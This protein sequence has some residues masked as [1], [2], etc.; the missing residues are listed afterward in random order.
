[1]SASAP[2][3][4]DGINDPVLIGLFLRAPPVLLPE[5]VT[6]NQSDRG[7]GRPRI[8]D[9][10][11]A[12]RPRSW[13]RQRP[14]LASPDLT[15]LFVPLL[16]RAHHVSVCGQYD[17]DAHEGQTVIFT[18][19][20][21]ATSVL[22]MT[23]SGGL[24]LTPRCPLERNRLGRS[25]REIVP[26]LD[27]DATQLR[28]A[29]SIIAFVLAARRKFRCI[30]GSFALVAAITPVDGI[31][32]TPASAPFVPVHLY[33]VSPTGDDHN[34]GT[35]P[36]TAWAT[37]R[38]PVQ[39]G[40]VIIA[41]AGR[42][43]QHVFGTNSWGDVANCPSTRDGV[44]GGG[45]VYFATLLCAGP[46]ITS[47]S[48]DG[49]AYEAF[50]VDASNWAVEGFTATQNSTGNSACFSAT[51]ETDTTLHHI[52]F[53]NDIAINC[54]YSGF[55][56]YSWTSPGG[57]DQT[58]V[59]GVIAYNA[60]S[61]FGGGI[62]SSGVSIVP[63]DGPDAELGTHVFVAGYFGYEN[64][65]AQSGAGCN[66]DGEELIFELLGMHKVHPPGC[67]RTECLVAKREL[68]V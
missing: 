5:L 35:S 45:G 38:H 68:R 42:Y 9:A 66:T 63:V 56:S 44:D 57:V 12:Q 16:P 33:Y 39:C 61:S 3:A 28:P 2:T 7:E 34:S 62:C 19:L 32:K 59:V 43:R 17:V 29:A 21:D 18:H 52:A 58:A 26:R 40:D 22:S 37:P 10:P 30:V 41:A 13:R 23:V 49:G 25:A 1:M 67:R 31:A 15:P 64:I 47:C 6:I 4:G 48:V 65:N 14:A 60:S 8:S 11:Q 51:S 53:I 24:Q 46:D 54:H 27:E 36:A 55:N 50:R 20:P